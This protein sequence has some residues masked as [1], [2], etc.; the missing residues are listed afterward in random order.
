MSLS[1]CLPIFAGARRLRSRAAAH[2]PVPAQ[3]R[4]R[5]VSRKDMAAAAQQKQQHRHASDDEDD[6]DEDED[7]DEDDDDKDSDGSN[8]SEGCRDEN[9]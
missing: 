8:G 2:E 6:Q 9:R 3:Y 1:F 5:V 7:D 4:G